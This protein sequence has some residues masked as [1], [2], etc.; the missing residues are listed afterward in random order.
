MTLATTPRYNPARVTRSDGHA[1]V[2]G[3]SV[4]GLLAGRVLSDAF[5]EVTVVEKDPL[6]EEAVARNG[7]PQAK[8]AHLLM[9]AGRATIED[10]LPGYCEGLLESG[11]LLL[12]G[13]TDVK[14]YIGGGF[15]A[16]GTERTPMYAAS[17]PLFE[18]EIRTRV[19]D[20]PG[21]TFHGECSFVEYLSDGDDRID[22]VRIRENETERELRADLVVDATGR[23]SRTP[24]WLAANGYATPDVEEV[25]VGT[26]YSTTRFERPEDERWSIAMLPDA[27]RKRGWVAFPIEGGEWIVGLAGIHGARPPT[28]PEAFE[29][30]IADRPTNVGRRFV[31]E[32]DFS[33]AEIDAYPFPSN[34]RRYYEALEAFPEGLVVVGD[35]I[36]SFNP[37]YGQGMS[38]AALE[39]IALHDC[40]ADG[41]RSNIATAF[42]DRAEPI[43][44]I[45]WR[46]AIGADFEFEETTGPK[47]RG[48]SVFNRYI[49]RLVRKAH[50]DGIL[51]SA[52]YR[53]TMLEE[54]PTALLRPG[55][56][57]RVVSPR[58]RSTGETIDPVEL[59][60]RSGD[61]TVP[62]DD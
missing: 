42:F 3:A 60:S 26:N 59:V 62:S 11:A 2:I 25:P 34:I 1:V 44:D 32:Y 61:R 31:E 9:E 47:P 52:F 21:V 14:Q 27:P 33:T 50:T 19:R 8:H 4:A 22:G 23:T 28:D 55:I 53:V 15:M 56:F 46:M 5:G 43:V 24:E 40:L 36:S 54:P 6:P 58:T 37:I 30:F 48:L 17:R 29:G 38:V 12:D 16:D 18:R 13:S 41:Y 45:A 39:S 10:L 35:A 20:L 7:V 51:R 49:S 57:R